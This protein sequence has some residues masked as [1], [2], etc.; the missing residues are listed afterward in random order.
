M[1]KISFE[2]NLKTRKNVVVLYKLDLKFC[3]VTF[4]KEI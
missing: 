2:N 3:N 4:D 1:Q